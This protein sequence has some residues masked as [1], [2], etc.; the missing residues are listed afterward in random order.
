MLRHPDASSTIENLTQPPFLP[1]VPD[2]EVTDAKRILI[3]SRSRPR[4][5]GRAAQT[6]GQQIPRYCF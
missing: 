5:E 6:Q 4:P 3:A 1:V 2:R